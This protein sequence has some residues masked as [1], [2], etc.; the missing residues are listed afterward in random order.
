MSDDDDDAA[1][2][3]GKIIALY[4][5]PSK[6]VYVSFDVLTGRRILRKYNTGKIL[7]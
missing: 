6:M 3:M 5:M 7:P 2:P 1:I 4:D